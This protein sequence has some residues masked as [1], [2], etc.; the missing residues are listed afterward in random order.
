MKTVA[1]K[2]LPSLDSNQQY[3]L[4]VL[5]L[6]KMAYDY[7]GMKLCYDIEG[8]NLYDVFF[9]LLE[10]LCDFIYAD[11]YGPFSIWRMNSRYIPA[12]FKQ[13]HRYGAKFGVPWRENPYVNMADDFARMKLGQVEDYSVGFEVK[14]SES[15]KYILIIFYECFVQSNQI[16]LALYKIEEY[17][18]NGIE[19]I[20]KQM[21]KGVPL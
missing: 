18:K 8:D 20:K 2:F 3:S 5:Y 6:A 1:E 10:D 13:C 4:G 12:Y 17:F 11:E 21:R 15:R 19:D 14:F 16:I 7:Q 9:E